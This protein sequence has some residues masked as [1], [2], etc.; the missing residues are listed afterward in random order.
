MAVINAVSHRNGVAR[1]PGIRHRGLSNFSHS[2][3]PRYEQTTRGSMTHKPQRVSHATNFLSA[4]A[5]SSSLQNEGV[6]QSTVSVA[7]KRGVHTSLIDAE[8]DL[9]SETR[10]AH[11]SGDHQIHA[12]APHT[13]LVRHGMGSGGSRRCLRIE[14]SR[15]SRATATHIAHR[16]GMGCTTGSSRWGPTGFTSGFRSFTASNTDWHGGGPGPCYYVF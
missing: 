15:S 14:A 9:Q 13:T 5:T 4:A 2:S 10:T 16:H 3:P 1:L 7:A 6:R 8:W 12:R 11:Q